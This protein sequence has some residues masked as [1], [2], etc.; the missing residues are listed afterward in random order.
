MENREAGRIVARHLLSQGFRRPG[1]LVGRTD[2]TTTEERLDGLRE[3]YAAAGMPI[4]E[5]RIRRTDL[6]EDGAEIAAR[7]LLAATEPPD[8]VFASNGPSTVGAFRAIQ[9]LGLGLPHDVGLV[10]TDDDVWTRM[11][12]PA[13]TVIQQPVRKIGRLAAQLLLARSEGTPTPTDQIVL[14]PTLI[15][16]PS[17]IRV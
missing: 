13:I 16:R 14:P 11:V 12:T 2:V 5:D 1:C 9:G 7:S 15:P 3:I 8:C 17:T 10:G 4:S 6:R